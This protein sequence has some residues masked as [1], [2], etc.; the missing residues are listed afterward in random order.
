M[1]R[2]VTINMPSLN[3]FAFRTFI[4]PLIGKPMMN[5]SMQR[6]KEKLEKKEAGDP[7]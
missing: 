3:A 4:Y 1:V 6:L 7:L 5:R 2:V